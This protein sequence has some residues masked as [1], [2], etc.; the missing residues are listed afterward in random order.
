MKGIT[1]L[2]AMLLVLSTG[3]YAD[4]INIKPYS[5]IQTVKSISLDS[6]VQSQLQIVLAQ[7]YSNFYKN[8]EE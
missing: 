1:I 3:A 4:N 6:T 2:G 5:S 8:F 7:D